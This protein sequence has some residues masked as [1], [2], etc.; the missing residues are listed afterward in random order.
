MCIRDS[1]E[2]LDLEAM[3]LAL[4]AQG[5]GHRADLTARRRRGTVG[6]VDRH[7][8]RQLSLLQEGLI[9]LAAAISMRAIIREVAKTAG[10]ASSL[11]RD[12][13]SA[14]SP[15]WTVRLASAD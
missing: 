6:D 7:P 2:R 13:A 1:I 9:S 10:K 5:G 3:E 14:V 11:E 4:H 12:S 15:G 8:D